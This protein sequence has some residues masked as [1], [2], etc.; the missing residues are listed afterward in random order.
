MT[1]GCSSIHTSDMQAGV[2]N[3]RCAS[4]G[5][6][7]R[8]VKGWEGAT[9]RGG[10]PQP[11]PPEGSSHTVPTL[12]LERREEHGLAPLAPL[13][14]V[15]LLLRDSILRGDQLDAQPGLVGGTAAQL[16]S[17][18]GELGHPSD[19]ALVLGLLWGEET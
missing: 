5:D 3:L 17:F 10:E 14:L 6:S 18:K 1:S 16:D 11:R 15:A 19:V 12:S 4:L 13:A 7:P 8:K 9:N 2:V